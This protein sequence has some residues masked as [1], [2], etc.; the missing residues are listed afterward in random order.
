[1]S[2]CGNQTKTI[3]IVE[4]K[5]TEEEF[6]LNKESRSEQRMAICKQCP[7]LMTL[8][9]C[10]YCKCFMNVKTRIYSATCPIGRW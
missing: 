7:N 5:E 1:M 9:M 4:A 10:G 6:L 3:D 2:C 8:N